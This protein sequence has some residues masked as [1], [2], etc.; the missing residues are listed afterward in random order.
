[1]LSL[2]NNWKLYILSVALISSLYLNVIQNF[3]NL[4]TENK[5]IICQGNLAANNIAIQ[6]ANEM[7]TRQQEQ[8]RLREQEAAHARAESL[9]RMDAIMLA[10]VP[11][12][13]QGVNEW[14]VD[15][16][17]EFDWTNNIP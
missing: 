8:L 11:Q 14:L 4:K 12:D 1:M 5:L 3:K 7:R 6:A 2:L 13:C 17:L 15:Q 9:K 10:T 16:A